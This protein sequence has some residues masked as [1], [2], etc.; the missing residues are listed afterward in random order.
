M[1]PTPAG[2]TAAEPGSAAASATGLTDA[3]TVGPTAQVDPLAIGTPR[4]ARSIGHTSY[5]LKVTLDNGSVG[6]FKPKSKKPLGDRR[7]KGE[8]AAFRLARALSVENVP[9]TVGRT[10][11]AADVRNA[12]GLEDKAEFDQV[13][14][15]GPEGDLEGALTQ[16]IDG[17]EVLPLETPAW[18]SRWMP[19]LTDKAV[20]VDRSDRAMARAISTLIA[21]DCV[22]ANWDRWSGANVARDRTTGTVLYVDNDGAFYDEPP[23][24]ELSRQFALLGR[25]ARFSR[26]FVMSLR[27]L[28][29]PAMH[30]V[31]ERDERGSPLLSERN[32]AA[33]ESR[34]LRVLQIVD[35]AIG[36]QGEDRALSF[37]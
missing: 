20:E 25:V 28:D 36:R 1:T 2:T 15:P 6:A 33:A 26:S 23:A 11:R 10:F 18:R 35:A 17:Y 37:D 3:S 14:R 13:A 22:T 4:R 29:G 24:D 8:I 5:V 31:L 9:R 7:Y 16:W 19:W 30:S 32:A 21:F 27:A 34:R 12:L